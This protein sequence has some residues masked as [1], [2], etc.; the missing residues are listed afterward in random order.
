MTIWVSE[1]PVNGQA[2]HMLVSV[3]LLGYAGLFVLFGSSLNVHTKPGKL[4]LS[5]NIIG[6]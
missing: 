3:C 2:C 5:Q 6:I 4:R 1:A